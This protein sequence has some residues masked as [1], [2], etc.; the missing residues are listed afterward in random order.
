MVDWFERQII[1]ALACPDRCRGRGHRPDFR[2]DPI[3]PTK[4]G[5]FLRKAFLVRTT[6]TKCLHAPTIVGHPIHKRQLLGLI[7]TNWIR[8][9][10]SSG[11]TNRIG[12]QNKIRLFGKTTH[13]C[14]LS[15]PL[16]RRC[17]TVVNFC[18]FL[19]I[20]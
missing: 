11:K 1:L 13:L 3:C 8:F 2:R 19:Y 20:N 18:V 6:K 10:V 17:V 7:R 14:I 15:R 9:S 4:T 16:S 5:C 12:C